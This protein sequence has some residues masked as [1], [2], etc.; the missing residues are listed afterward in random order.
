MH[1]LGLLKNSKNNC[2]EKVNLSR[3]KV[4][5]EEDLILAVND[6]LEVRSNEISY[7]LPS[8]TFK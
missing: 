7:A 3:R 1:N 4:T 8:K 5:L 6:I 2:A